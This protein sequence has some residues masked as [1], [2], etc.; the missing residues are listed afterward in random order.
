MIESDWELIPDADTIEMEAMS[1]SSYS[2]DTNSSLVGNASSTLYKSD[3]FDSQGEQ[4]SA[5]LV[6]ESPKHNRYN[7]PLFKELLAPPIEV[8]KI[9]NQSIPDDESISNLLNMA[10]IITNSQTKLNALETNN[11]QLITT[12]HT[13]NN[14]PDVQFLNDVDPAKDLTENFVPGIPN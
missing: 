10:K 4:Q 3:T 5:D 14:A 11:S 2:I 1:E 12:N 13:N 7:S 6:Y 9:T 8:I